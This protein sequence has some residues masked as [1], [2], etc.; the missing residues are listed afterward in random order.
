MRPVGISVCSRAW[1]ERSSSI[2][3]IVVTVGVFLE[4]VIIVF[5]LFSF[6]HVFLVFYVVIDASVVIVHHVLTLGRFV[7][8][9]L[10]G[11]PNLVVHVEVET[12]AQINEVLLVSAL[13]ILLE[14]HEV[15]IE[16]VVQLVELLDGLV[17]DLRNLILRI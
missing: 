1:V 13:E 15:T 16:V 2:I 5:V 9:K 17:V 11:L 3:I 10:L 7:A 4:V 8:A 6:I 12:R 14:R